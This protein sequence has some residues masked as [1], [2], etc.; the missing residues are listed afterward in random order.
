M[1]GAALRGSHGV[2]G[3]PKK[4]RVH[5]SMAAGLCYPKESSGT[6]CPSCRRTVCH[7]CRDGWLGCHHFVL[8]LGKGQTLVW[9]HCGGQEGRKSLSLRHWRA[10]LGRVC[11]VRLGPTSVALWDGTWLT[12]LC[13]TAV[14]P[15]SSKEPLLL[16]SCGAEDA[17]AHQ[18]QGE[19]W[20][21]PVPCLIPVAG[22]TGNILHWSRDVP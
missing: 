14:S 9:V 18:G 22:P 7:G 1:L 11:C 6:G 19:S 13:G 3:R 20:G 8:L 16:F 2:K 12:W 5:P 17:P 15:C 21:P 4:E 10:F